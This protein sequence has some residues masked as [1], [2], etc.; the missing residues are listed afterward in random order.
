MCNRHPN[1]RVLPQHLAVV[2]RAKTRK[3][4]SLRRV[5]LGDLHIADE[6]AFG[7][8]GLYAQLKRH[9]RIANYPFRLLPADAE[10]WDDALLL[11]LCFWDT[12]LGGDVLVDTTLP[13]DVVCHIAWHHLAHIRLTEGQLPLAAE[14]LILGE[15]IASAFDL[16]LV[17]RLIDSAA[18]SDFISTQVPAMAEVAES[19]GLEPEQ[20]AGI[21]DQVRANPEVAFESLRQLLFDTVLGLL[22]APN[23][24]SA[25][26][27]LRVA[28]QH[29]FGCL[30]H[31]FEIA[32]WLL[33]ARAAPQNASGPRAKEVDAQLR[34]QA[35]ALDW[36]QL[37]WL[38]ADLAAN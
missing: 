36:L 7:R 10:K 11:N 13:A 19:A 1:R 38:D 32:N 31:H 2:D 20:F 22:A 21:L 25:H 33:H 15:S 6:P 3:F 18:S 16:Y 9:L 34:N 30:L 26:Q 12:S 29:R 35:I 23:A 24:D 5:T 14:A 17:G 37:H 8:V 28:S 27:V 4:M